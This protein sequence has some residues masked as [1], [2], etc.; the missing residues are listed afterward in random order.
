MTPILTK[1][2]ATAD[3]Q[4]AHKEGRD[5]YISLVTLVARNAEREIRRLEERAELNR[6]SEQTF[7]GVAATMQR[8]IENDEQRI[9]L[10]SEH[11][12]RLETRLQALERKK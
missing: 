7:L 4:R 5:P 2:V 10:L 9:Q 3:A 1:E 8:R 6:D 11:V 12:N